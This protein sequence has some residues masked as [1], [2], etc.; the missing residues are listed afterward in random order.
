M[1][2]DSIAWSEDSYDEIEPTT[3]QPLNDERFLIRR[4]RLR[5]EARRDGIVGS[6]ELDGNTIDGPEARILAAQVGYEYPERG[7]PVVGITAG[8]FRTPFGAEVPMAE[9]VK[10][11]LEPPTFARA[12]IPGNYDAGVMAYGQAGIARWAVAVMNGAPVGDAQ[13]RGRDP[14]ASYE[15]VGRI[16]A[17]IEGPRKFRVEAGVSALAGSGIHPGDPPIKEG[18]QWVD[19]NNDGLVNANTEL[20]VVRGSPGT[21]SETFDRQ[22][23]GGDLQLHWCFCKIGNGTAFAEAVIATN[24]DRG[25][26]YADPIA[27][28]RDLRHF[29][30]AVGFVQNITR[31]AMVGAR[32]DRYNADR[33]RTE[34]VGLPIVGVDQVFSTLSILA[35]GTWKEARFAVQYD[36]ERNPFGRDDTGLPIT[37]EADRLTL[38]AQVGF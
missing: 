18:L 7:T 37:R 36:H 30:F 29:G 23:I 28:S 34:R 38:R 3:G 22:A 14:V 21:P 15:L 6:F 35:A 4:G 10:P 24:L 12:L 26:I 5:A 33:D 1:Q 32:Y 19:D 11:F 8:L 17:V 9:R 25:I 27:A 31:H 2:V 20:R 16:G 13:W